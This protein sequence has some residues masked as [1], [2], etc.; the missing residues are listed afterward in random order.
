MKRDAVLWAGLLLGP[1]VWL[2]SFLINYVLAPW[3]CDWRWKPAL[4]GVSLVAL[5]ITAS[6]GWMAWQQW[7]ALGRRM[8]DDRAGEAPRA[9]KMAAGGVMLSALSFLVVLAQSLAEVIL[10]ACE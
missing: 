4:Y 1:L 5:T 3:A 7:T 2:T 8:D 10:G 6:T 9:R